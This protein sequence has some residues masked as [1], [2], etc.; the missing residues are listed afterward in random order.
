MWNRP[1][2]RPMLDCKNNSFRKHF[3][4]K[5]ILLSKVVD[6]VEVQTQF[7]WMKGAVQLARPLLQSPFVIVFCLYNCLHPFLAYCCFACYTLSIKLPKPVR[8][9]NRAFAPDLSKSVSWSLFMEHAARALTCE[10]SNPL[11]RAEVDISHSGRGL[12]R[13]QVDFVHCCGLSKLEGMFNIHTHTSTPTTDPISHEHKNNTYFKTSNS[14][15]VLYMSILGVSIL[16]SHSPI[17]IMFKNSQKCQIVSQVQHWSFMVTLL[18]FAQ[19]HFACQHSVNSLLVT[20][21][22]NQLHTHTHIP[23]TNLPQCVCSQDL[24]QKCWQPLI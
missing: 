13:P 23:A 4:L 7:S 11:D 3:L 18:A 12:S 20:K 19:L 6:L 24:Y 10:I 17:K 2:P 21:F 15:G 16:K 22:S 14:F 9:L 1:P 8:T 5:K